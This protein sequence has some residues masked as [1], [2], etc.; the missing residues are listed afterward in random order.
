[1]TS[2]WDVIGSAR[3]ETKS[4]ST[5]LADL[6]ELQVTARMFGK[7]S[8]KWIY[9]IINTKCFGIRWLGFSFLF[10]PARSIHQ[11]END[12]VRYEKR[13]F[14]SSLQKIL[15]VSINIIFHNQRVCVIFYT[16]LS[17]KLY[18]FPNNSTEYETFHP[19]GYFIQLF[20][21]EHL[22]ARW[23]SEGIASGTTWDTFLKTTCSYTYV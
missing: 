14:K 15:W 17:F 3:A 8:S 11:K 4:S 9:H 16:Y 19:W 23:T 13:D 6:S 18:S 7:F 10:S 20:S 22:K 1:M 2:K 12:A 5:T 21:V